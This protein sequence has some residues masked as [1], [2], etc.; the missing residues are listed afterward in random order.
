MPGYRWIR[1]LGEGSAGRVVLAVHVATDTPV[2]IK[3]LSQRMLADE[4]FV[5]RFRAEARLLAGIRDPNL[6]RFHEYVESVNKNAIPGEPPR[7]AA[8]VMELVDGVSLARL[9][10]AEGATGPEAALAI[11]KGSLL[12]LAAAHAAGV[13]HRD[14]KPG[15]ILVR[16]DGASKL[17]D[18]GIAVRAGDNVPAAGTPA[19]MPP[20]Q[21]AGRPVTPAS[22]VYAATAV[23]FECLTGARP[24]QGRTLPQLALAH[25]TAPVPVEQVPEALRGLVGRGMAKAAHDRPQS[26]MAFVEELETTALAAYGPNWEERGR[27]RLAELAALLALLFPLAEGT[28]TDGSAVAETVLGAT[29]AAGAGAE[30]GAVGGRTARRLVYMVTAATVVLLLSGG[31]ILAY[32]IN[33]SGNS[34]KPGAAGPGST[35]PG[36][37]LAGS[38]ADPSGGPSA[39]P[40]SPGASPTTTTPAPTPAGGPGAAGAG[41]GAAPGGGTVTLPPLVSI[42]G[43]STSAVE[44]P[45]PP[46]PFRVTDVSVSRGV[47]D[48][49]T[50]SWAVSVTTNRPSGEVRLSITF[51]AGGETLAGETQQKSAAPYA[52]TAQYGKFPSSCQDWTV[53]VT[54]EPGGVQ[55]SN[56]IPAEPCEIG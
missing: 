31:G 54:A 9:I 24:F 17:S 21:W 33:S 28:V 22:D 40:S 26:A 53:T 6:V 20:E 35:A 47:R 14:Y 50:G 7:G 5:T 23:F 51:L 42:P 1:D 55:G 12:G 48:G 46:P 15:N 18:F 16:G 30:A 45:P 4:E 38:S 36:G 52:F 32:T 37:P 43:G 8:I 10:K 2:A 11:L 41:G 49:Q 56:T 39:E 44:Q 13:V 3:Y 34:A 25:R 19:Y 27:N 29:A